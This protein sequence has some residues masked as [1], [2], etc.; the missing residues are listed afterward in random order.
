MKKSMKPKYVKRR[1]VLT[2]LI[3]QAVVLF[4]AIVPTIWAL[5]G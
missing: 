5:N 1:T 3:G 4:Y 2:V